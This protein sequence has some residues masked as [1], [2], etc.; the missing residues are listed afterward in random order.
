[1]S[2]HVIQHELSYF[3][4]YRMELDLTRPLPPVPA[5]PANCRWVPWDDA[6]LPVHADVKARCFANEI[7][8]FV[9]PNL[10]SVDGCLR[11]MREIRGKL[12][13]RPQ[14][15]WL[16]AQGDEYVGTIQGIAE[17]IG[18]GAI[19]NVGVVDGHRGHG[20]GTALLVRALHGFRTTGLSLARLD[21]TSN[22]D[23]AIRLY[24][25]LGFRFKKTLYKV[26]DPLALVAAQD[27]CV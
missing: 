11:L 1:M 25:K 20:L 5:I 14:S 15:T 13:F 7:D 21:V 6:L 17:R 10:G 26:A 3:K 16:V 2:T 19:Q 8:R 22:N 18:I 12:G 4:R 27:W 9:F 23:A 24:R